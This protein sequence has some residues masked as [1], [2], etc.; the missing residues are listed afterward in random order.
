MKK[1]IVF[2]L[3]LFALG[4]SCEKPN[5]PNGDNIPDEIDRAL[6]PFNTGSFW[7]FDV[8]EMTSEGEFN[9]FE[10]YAVLNIIAHDGNRV[11]KI[12]FTQY[13]E[14]TTFGRFVMWWGN[15][16]DGLYE[17]APFGE[18]FNPHDAPRLLFLFPAEDMDAF[19]SYAFD[20]QDPITMT[21]FDIGIPP[22]DLPA[23][24]FDECVGYNLSR[25]VM[26]DPPENNY[27]YFKPD[28][29]YVRF[30]KYITGSGLVKT[31]SLRDFL[32]QDRLSQLKEIRHG[33]QSR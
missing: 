11:A 13:L 17:F 10:K 23:G 29:G 1:T 15:T 26:P 3:I 21:Y 22:F 14:D 9:Y 18:V 16:L 24:R 33:R 25:H 31:R 7:E 28:T 19:G 30:E 32:V 4:L 27:Y 2:L 20:F 8:W 6:W 12:E 5:G